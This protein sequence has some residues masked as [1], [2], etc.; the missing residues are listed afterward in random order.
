MDS[1]LTASTYTRKQVACVGKR[2]S[3]PLGAGQATSHGEQFCAMAGQ[4]IAV[5]ERRL[6]RPNADFLQWHL[7]TV[8]RAA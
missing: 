6:D 7:D 2:E 8:Y 1:V 3:V 4:P 5:P